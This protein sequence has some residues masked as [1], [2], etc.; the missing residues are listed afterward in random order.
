MSSPYQIQNLQEYHESYKR[1]VA[2]PSGFWSDI[3]QHFEWKKPWNAVC[4]WNFQ[5]PSIRWFD[6]AEL[7][8][9][10]NALDRHVRTQPDA[11]AII[12]EPNDPT[13]DA[14]RISYRELLQ[15]VEA[16]CHVYTDLGITKGDRVCLY[17]PMVPEL[18]L[19]CSLV[20][21]WAPCT[22]LFLAV[23]AH[24]ALPTALMMQS[25]NS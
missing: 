22:R 7:N 8:I 17:M 16:L 14:V 24:K 2:D 5:E 12:W 9:T 25:A 20:P 23:S 21:A 1:S 19:L 10:E 18:P 15:R 11:I 3:A 4:D 13:E 6:G